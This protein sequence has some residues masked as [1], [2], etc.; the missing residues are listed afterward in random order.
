M[1]DASASMAAG[2]GSK[3]QRARELAIAILR[4]ATRSGCSATLWAT[5]G[6]ERNRVVEGSE[7]DRVA[8]VPFD[9][10]ATLVDAWPRNLGTATALRV[11]LSD[12]LFATDPAT[13]VDRAAADTGRL[14][15]IQVLDPWELDPQPSGTTRLIDA[16]TEQSVALT[17]DAGTVERYKDRLAA[18]QQAYAERCRATGAAWMIDT[19]ADH[20]EHLCQRMMSVG[21]LVETTLGNESAIAT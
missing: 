18:L 20:L 15:M 10:T 19:P 3:E 1:L 5:R 14:L 11:V 7:A 6:A 17:L 4:I 21:I 9:G 8:L 2:D 16:E 12:F 13:L